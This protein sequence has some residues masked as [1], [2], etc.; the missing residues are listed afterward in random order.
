MRR[1][2]ALGFV[3][4]G[5]Q[6]GGPRQLQRLA[7]LRVDVGGQRL[8]DQGQL[9]GIGFVE[10]VALQAAGGFALARG[11]GPH[12]LHAR[13]RRF[14]GAAQAVVDHHVFGL[15]G[16]GGQGLASHG[17]ER[18][19]ALLDEHPLTH[20][21]HGL[22][23]HRLYQHRGPLVGRGGQTVQGGDAVVRLTRHQ[24]QR[25]SRCER[26]GGTRAKPQRQPQPQKPEPMKFH[27][28]S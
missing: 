6:H 5:E 12:Q 27:N 14:H 19:V 7:R 8:V 4:A 2:Q 3:F 23:R 26:L 15:F 24:R 17:V 11:I 28:H 10:S 16:H 25:V 18:A 20:H 22:V 9:R 1:L 21:A 13:Q